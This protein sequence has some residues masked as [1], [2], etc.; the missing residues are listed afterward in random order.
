MDILKKIRSVVEEVTP[1]KDLSKVDRSGNNAVYRAFYIKI[2]RDHTKKS[3]KEIGKE[4][5]RDHTTVL[6][7]CR[8]LD[9]TIQFDKG[10]QEM[11][12]KIQSKC[13]LI[14]G[15]E[16]L[17]NRINRTINRMNDKELLELYNNKLTTNDN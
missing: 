4:I 15:R 14:S 5:N 13:D 11:Y 12:R 8:N 6:Y 16:V 2:A 1:L 3:Y 7:W 9:S 17:I 10:L